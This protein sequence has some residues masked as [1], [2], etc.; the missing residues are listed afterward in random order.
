MGRGDF[1]RGGADASTAW[2]YRS[3]VLCIHASK[4]IFIGAQ[5]LQSVTK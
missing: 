2:R 1:G 5:P 4:R 3:S